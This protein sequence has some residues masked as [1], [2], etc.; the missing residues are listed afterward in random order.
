MLPIAYSVDSQLE[1]LNY[2]DVLVSRFTCDMPLVFVMDYL[3]LDITKTE[4]AI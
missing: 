4:T 2:K 3:R 1:L